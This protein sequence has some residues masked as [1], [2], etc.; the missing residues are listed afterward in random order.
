MEIVKT[1]KKIVI[2]RREILSD[3]KP[4]EWSFTTVEAAVARIDY[5]RSQAGT[6][7]YRITN[8]VVDV[9]SY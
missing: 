6:E 9:Y 3:W 4:V 8:S 2:E 7:I 5:L 1:T